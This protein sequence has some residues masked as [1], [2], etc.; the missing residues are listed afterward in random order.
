MA[1]GGPSLIPYSGQTR[2]H[3]R[4][5]ERFKFANALYYLHVTGSAVLRTH[6]QE[7]LAIA[8]R[9]ALEQGRPAG[10]P[11]ILCVVTNPISRTQFE[12]A[13]VHS[14]DA[15]EMIRDFGQFTAT[16]QRQCIVS[17]HRMFVNLALDLLQELLG[18]G[19][20]F[21][22]SALDEKIQSRFIRPKILHKTWKQIGVPLSATAKGDNNLQR[23]AELRNV[24]EHNDE[25]ANPIYCK[26]YPEHQL[27]VGDP[28]PVGNREVGRAFNLVSS[29][30]DDLD[31]RTYAR[32][33]T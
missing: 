31:R 5:R 17:A 24:I 18:Q 2:S 27:K 6:L 4:F 16:I 9:T 12:A 20:I 13:V 10:W 29:L 11:S 1:S 19:L 25:K 23:L 14:L 28:V 3:A 8:K 15:E 26:L 32:W 7:Q 33:L 21:L 30:G 22:P